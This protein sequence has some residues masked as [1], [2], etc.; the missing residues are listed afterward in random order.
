MDREALAIRRIWKRKTKTMNNEDI[1][2]MRE[3]DLRVM[4]KLSL[5]RFAK[6]DGVYYSRDAFKKEEAEEQE[7][8]RKAA[9]EMLAFIEKVSETRLGECPHDDAQ[10]LKDLCSEARLLLSEIESGEVAS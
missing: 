4:K 5:Y 3:V 8:L 9:P 1:D 7:R 6:N 2:T 10:E